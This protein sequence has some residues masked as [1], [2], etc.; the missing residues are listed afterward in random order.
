MTLTLT[1]TGRNNDI[2]LDAYTLKSGI[3]QQE[4]FG[5]GNGAMIVGFWF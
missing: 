5:K 1:A 4:E 2:T 3:T